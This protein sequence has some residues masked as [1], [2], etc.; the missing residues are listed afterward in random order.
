MGLQD[1]A[2]SEMQPGQ[3]DQFVARLEAMQGVGE[4]GID[5]EQCLGA[6]SNAWLGASAIARSV[7]RTTPIGRTV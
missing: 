6:P 5:L 1:L 7:E 4:R 3:D 2:V